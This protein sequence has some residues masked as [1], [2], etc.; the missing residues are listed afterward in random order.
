MGGAGK[1]PMVIYLAKLLV[2]S[3][4]KPGIVS[5]GYG[6]N[7]RGLVKVHDGKKFVADVEKAG[8]ESYIMGKELNNIPIISHPPNQ[9]TTQHQ[10]NPNTHDST[11]WERNST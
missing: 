11:S 8:D 6:R 7:S 5:R 9:W 4:C 1:T 10:H 3:G 2:K